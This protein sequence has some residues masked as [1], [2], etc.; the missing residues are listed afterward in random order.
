MKF[1]RWWGL[2]AFFGLL[3][4]VTMVWYLLAP[5]LIKN[6]IEE[7]G[8]EVLGAKV[9]IN[10]VE[11]SL[12]PV[13]VAINNLVAADPELPLK[14]LFESDQI[15]FAVDAGALLW[16]KIVIE[17]LVL[18][19]VKIA[20]KREFS[21]ALEGG[22][23]STQA[24]EKA[25]EVALPDISNLDINELVA[26]ADLIT[27]KRIDKLKQEQNKLAQ[28]WRTV[29][30]KDE[31]DNRIVE[32]KS[33]YERLAKRAKK[34]KLN[35]IKDRK[36][37]K[38]LKQS[39]DAERKQIASLSDKLKRDKRSLSVQ[40]KLVKHG[41]RDDM[42][43]IMGQLGVNDGV[44]GLVEKY[45]GPQYTPWI[46]KGLEM[47]K[48]FKPRE[49]QA[50]EK[51][52]VIQLGKKV[53]FNDQHV[54]PE[55]LIKKI[56]LS[57]SNQGWKLNGK[58][59]DLGYL[60]WLTGKP[61]KLSFYLG[62]KG[63]AKLDI[64]SDWSSANKMLTKLKSSVTNWSLESMRFMQTEAGEWT[65]N[66][67]NLTANIAGEF[68][69]DKIN[70]T[71]SFS[72]SSPKLRVPE[73]ISPWQKSLA[74]SVNHEAKIDFKLTASGSITEPKIKID[75]SLEKLFKKAIGDK[76]KKEAEKLSGKVKQSIADKVGD[77]SA[78]EN[79]NSNFDQW[80][81]QMS[82]KDNRLQNLLGKIKF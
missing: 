67:G 19:G 54:F 39:I 69:L 62:G 4:V 70:I 17:E 15:K 8:S 24:I 49:G 74:M 81:S 28:E 76:V 3:L 60:P 44:E 48:S 30:D 41:P 1:I 23:K 35:L 5:H 82:E 46:T 29:L 37:W 58:G 65:L 16:K 79:F 73:N 20:T 57:G 72:I 64:T 10:S 52:A 18:T 27:L 33:E 2:I 53:V 66:S 9:E 80:Q 40:L 43:A 50:K 51:Q 6:S 55:L 59:F 61:A 26:K 71:A 42:K 38:K 32:I 13:S 11:L 47:V 25:I 63:T 22:R 21:G 68:T 75:S 12:F 45:L 77:I 78:L 56:K 31:F 7:L 34:N 14:N 36:S